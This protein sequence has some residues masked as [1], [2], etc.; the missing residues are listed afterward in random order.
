MP[1]YMKTSRGSRVICPCDPSCDH[2]VNFL[3]EL[4]D[5]PIVLAYGRDVHDELEEWENAT[6]SSA[7]A[8]PNIPS[9]T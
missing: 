9:R 5:D 1:V 3:C 8:A 2:V 7:S 6:S 4:L